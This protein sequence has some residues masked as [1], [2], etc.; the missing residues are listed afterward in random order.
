MAGDQ[1][2]TSGDLWSTLR[3]PLPWAVQPVE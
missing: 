1:H 2:V 3:K